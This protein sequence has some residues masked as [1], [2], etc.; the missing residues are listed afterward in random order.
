MAA[1]ER[2]M[3]E[4]R[5]QDA[6]RERIRQEENRRRREEEERRRAVNREINEDIVRSMARIADQMENEVREYRQRRAIQPRQI[7]RANPER[8]TN[9]HDDLHLD[10]R[11]WQHDRRRW[12]L[13]RDQPILD[14]N[15]IIEGRP[16]NWQG[17]GREEEEQRRRARRIY[18]IDQNRRLPDGQ[19][20]RWHGYQPA[21]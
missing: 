14:E 3:T 2:R 4:W 13:Q 17:R 16:D 9:I 15:W 6:E 20:W 1:D 10:R 11:Q 7:P 18:E 5:R 21:A 8:Q 12:M 19:W